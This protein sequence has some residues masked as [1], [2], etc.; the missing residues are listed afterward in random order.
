LQQLALVV[1]VPPG[2]TQVA[3]VQRGMPRM[4]T[5]QV[6]PWQLPEQQSQRAL[7]DVVAVRHTFPSG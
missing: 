2:F 3:P 4:S 5:L 1:Q 6:L 7:H